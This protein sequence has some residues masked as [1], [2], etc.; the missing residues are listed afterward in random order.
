MLCLC[1]NKTVLHKPKYAME[2]KETWCPKHG[3]NNDCYL[4]NIESSGTMFSTEQCIR[5][6]MQS[7]QRVNL[8]RESPP[9]TP[10]ERPGKLPVRYNLGG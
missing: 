10:A 8:T 3:Y 9:S 2:A 1:K 6:R 4:C 5:H 7:N